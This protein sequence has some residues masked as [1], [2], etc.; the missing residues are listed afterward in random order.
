MPSVPL[1]TLAAT[2]R[3]STTFAAKVGRITSRAGDGDRNEHDHDG[4]AEREP[5]EIPPVIGER[6]R[7]AL[8][9]IICEI[10]A[11]EAES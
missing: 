5:G 7:L 4:P 3:N 1:W 2:E 8:G 6:R 10:R 9:C 11:Q